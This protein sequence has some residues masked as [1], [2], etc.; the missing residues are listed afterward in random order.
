MTRSFVAILL[1][2]A[3]TTYLRDSLRQFSEKVP[4]VS[5]VRPENMHVTVR[6]L[7]DLT[8]ADVA[9]VRDSVRRS[10]AS[11]RAPVARLGQLGAFHNPK[12]ATVLWVGFGQGEEEM[13]ALAR[14]IDEGLARDGFGRADKPFRAHVTVAR[15]RPGV[16]FAALMDHPFRNPPPEEPL[17]RLAVMKS[18]LH[19]SGARYTV[20]EELRLLEPAH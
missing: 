16:G 3:W 13:E 14:A 9:G 4:G 2:D 10:A 6:F 11:L 7:G 1:P 5:W 19:P 12:R 17:R 8:D 20:L 15:P 18:D